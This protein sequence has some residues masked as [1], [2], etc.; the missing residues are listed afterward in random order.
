[1]YI[2]STGLNH[3]TAPINIREKFIFTDDEKIQAESALLK[4][5]SLLENVIISTCNRTEIIAVVDQIHTGRYYLKRFLANWF[6]CSI[7][8]L[9]PYLFFHEEIAAVRHLYQVTAGLDS[10]VLGETQILGQVKKA[11]NEA[12][13]A[14]TTGTILNYLFREAIFFAKKAHHQFKINEN[15][16][17]VSYAAVEIAK[18]LYTDIEKKS[19]LLIG[20]GKMGKLALKNLHGSGVGNITITN[21][22]NEKS[23][24]LAKEFS[25]KTI[26][27]GQ[28]KDILPS[29]DIILVSTASSEYIINKKMMQDAL[30]KRNKELLMIDIAL[31]RNVNPNCADLPNLFLYDLDDLNGVVTANTTE[32]KRIV[33]KVQQEIEQ[34]VI[35]FY[36]WEKQLGVIPLIRELRE[37]ALKIQEETMHS[38]KNKL[39][40]LTDHEYLIIGKH[41]KSVI[42]QMLKHPVTEI[43]EMA[44]HDQSEL[45]IEAFKQIFDLSEENRNEELIN[46]TG[47][48]RWQSE[49]QTSSYSN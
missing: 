7:H 26:D 3:K 12:H 19:V 32:R 24:K 14:K 15:A 40:R 44:V 33:Q 21:R 28:I 47:N 37:N 38:L 49:K 31:P 35:A 1:M 13:L 11:F 17:S 42:N 30:K 27:F 23:E 39:P 25:A 36:E 16:V 8:D 22:T 4:E 29:I 48:H 46:E 9:E 43:K 20:A 6:D 2:L 45:K 41:M 5:K 34:A 18:Q 10:L